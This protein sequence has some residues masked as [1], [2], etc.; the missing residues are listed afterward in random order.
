MKVFVI[1][2]VLVGLTGILLS[3]DSAA[4][5]WIPA[6]PEKLVQQSKTIFV[7]NITRINL[8]DVEYQSQMARNGTVKESVSAETMQ[9]EEYT[10]HVQEFLKNPQETDILKVLRAT[11]SGVPSAP[12]KISGFDVGDRVL[13]YLPNDERQTHFE[14]QYLPESFLIP[15]ACDAKS[16]LYQPKIKLGNSFEILQNNIAKKDNFTAGIPMKFVYSTD[17]DDLNGGNIDI[18]VSIR[19]YAEQETVFDK[20]IHAESEPCEWITSAEWEFTPEKGD[21]RMYL[22][23]REND[24]DRGTTI[25]SGFSVMSKQND[26]YPLKQFKSGV[27]FNDIQCKQNLVL[28][29]KYDGSPACVTEQTKQKLIERGWTTKDSTVSV[30]GCEKDVPPREDLVFFDCKWVEVPYG[31]T[32]ENGRWQEDPTVL[33]LGP[34]PK[35]SCP[36]D[37]V[38]TCDGKYAFY[39]K[40]TN[41]CDSSPYVPQYYQS[42]CEQYADLDFQGWT[43]DENECDWN[44]LDEQDK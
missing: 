34:E 3:I 26:T 4:G 31:W 13:F 1:L 22:N 17:L 37:D 44:Q 41:R 20:N 39:N 15:E 21:Y 35:P 11:V 43:F 18:T 42:D 40:T 5:L 12:A 16:M 8:V 28:I 19:P 29:Q 27:P 2:I 7:G 6:S 32:Y 33:R 30:N 36:K 25:Y 24:E 14:G 38:C 9:L 23:I 10:V